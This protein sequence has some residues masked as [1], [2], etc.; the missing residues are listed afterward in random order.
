M[1]TSLPVVLPT[2]GGID[3]HKNTLTA[4]LLAT[5]ASGKAV[6]DV[7]TG[8]PDYYRPTD[9]DRLKDKLVQRLRKLGYTVTVAA[10]ETAA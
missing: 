9:T 4:C 1:D 10:A 2:C 3:V 8:G 6:Q 7:R 5:G